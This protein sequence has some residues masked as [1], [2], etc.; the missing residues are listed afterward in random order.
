MCGFD[1]PVDAASRT[2]RVAPSCDPPPEPVKTS[3]EY[4]M[5]RRK[6]GRLAGL[7]F[8][9]AVAFGGVAGVNGWY[10]S[11]AGSGAAHTTNSVVDWE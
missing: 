6:L 4:E 3:R 5:H 11:T 10:P 9:L 2:P 8:A 1:P 7:V